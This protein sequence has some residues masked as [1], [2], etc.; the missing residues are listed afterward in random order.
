MDKLELAKWLHDN[1]EEVAKTKGWNTQE[2]CKVEFDTLPDANKSTMIEIADRLLNFNLLSKHF[3]SGSLP[4]RKVSKLLKAL[5]DIR[6]WD[7][8]L[9]DEWEDQGYR[10]KAALAE[11]YKGNDH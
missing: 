8:D 4:Y 6:N 2:N 10:A 5:N 7:D 3:V 9:E 11:Y 1:Y